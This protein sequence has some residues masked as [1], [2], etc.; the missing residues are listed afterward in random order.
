MYIVGKDTFPDCWAEDSF[1]DCWAPKLS[2]KEGE[3]LETGLCGTERRHTE[4]RHLFPG[5]LCVHLKSAACFYLFQAISADSEIN[6]EEKQSKNS[7]KCIADFL[8]LEILIWSIFFIHL[9]S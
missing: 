9:A 7:S 5:C 1:P 3:R 4:K 6:C 2:N 8:S